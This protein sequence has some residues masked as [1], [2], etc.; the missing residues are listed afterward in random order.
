VKD[1]IDSVTGAPARLQISEV[2]LDEVKPRPA[3]SRDQR[4]DLIQVLSAPGRE[5]VKSHHALMQFEQRF[6]QVRADESG[7]T[8]YEPGAGFR[9]QRRL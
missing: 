9:L 7:D 1:V 6:E 8:R 4:S 3:S 5:V 2:S